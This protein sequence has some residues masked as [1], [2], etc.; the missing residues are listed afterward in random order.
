MKVNAM[1]CTKCGEKNERSAP[2]LVSLLGSFNTS[3]DTLL[4]VDELRALKKDDEEYAAEINRIKQANSEQ[5]R[6]KEAELIRALVQKDTEIT[7]LP[8]D[9]D[10]AAQLSD[11]ESKA[12]EAEHELLEAVKVTSFVGFFCVFSSFFLPFSARRCRACPVRT[13][14]LW[15]RKRAIPRWL[16]RDGRASRFRR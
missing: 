10:F 4:T 6:K 9:E 11:L 5:M 15:R 12:N 2:N 16:C 13:P 3:T 1:F 8:A 7:D 14:L